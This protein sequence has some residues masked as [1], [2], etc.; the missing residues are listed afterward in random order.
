MI[1]LVTSSANI[2]KPAAVAIIKY[3][4]LAGEKITLRIMLPEQIKPIN[5]HA[6]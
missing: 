3:V 4:I 5:L 2:Q 6:H 1:M